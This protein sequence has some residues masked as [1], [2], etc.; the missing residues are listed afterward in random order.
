[1]SFRLFLPETNTDCTPRGLRPDA[2]ISDVL[3][4]V[5]SP[6]A[7]ASRGFR[8]VHLLYGGRLAVPT[9][10]ISDFPDP[11]HFYAAVRKG[12]EPPLAVAPPSPDEVEEFGCSFDSSVVQ[13]ISIY[14]L[15]WLRKTLFNL[16]DVI[17]S[18]YWLK[19]NKD[20]A[21]AQSYA[22]GVHQMVNHK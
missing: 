17:L 13:A 10:R 11:K 12:D 6:S 9:S 18:Y 7:V 4:V 3:S 14:D 2:L 15:Q 19:I 16:D 5:N 1:M 22:A 21:R 8:I 20:H